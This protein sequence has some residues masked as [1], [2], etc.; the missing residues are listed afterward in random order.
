M[1][2]TVSIGDV[3]SQQADAMLLAVSLACC[4]SEVPKD[5][6]VAM[7]DAYDTLECVVLDSPRPAPSLLFSACSSRHA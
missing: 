3:P 4:S 6:E 1:Q 7:L 2:K 5:M